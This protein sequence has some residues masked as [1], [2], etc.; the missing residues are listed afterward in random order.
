MSAEDIARQNEELRQAAE[1]PLPDD[2]EDDDL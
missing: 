1:M 2:D